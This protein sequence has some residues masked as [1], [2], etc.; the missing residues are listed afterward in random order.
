MHWDDLE[1]LGTVIGEGSLSGAARV[2]GLSQPTVGR[3]IRALEDAVGSTLIERVPEG[4]RPTALALAMLPHVDAMKRAAGELGRVVRGHAPDPSGSVRIACGFMVGRFLAIH[5]AELLEGA[6]DLRLVIDA[7]LAT[8]NLDRGDAD[9][10]LRANRP[11]SGNLYAKK[12][13]NNMYAVHGSRRYVEANP[14]ALGEDRYEG[15]RW[16]GYDEGHAH[17]AS[18]KWLA[19]RRSRAPE[20]QCTSSLLYF[21]AVVAG[22]GLGLLPTML[23]DRD[24]LVRLG[25]PLPELAYDMWLVAHRD[26][27]SIPRVRFVM[28]RVTA[29]VEARLADLSDDP[30]DD[31]A[32]DPEPDPAQ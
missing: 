16:V 24:D 2:L 9:L 6:P 22:A 29:L 26:A 12:I 15:C 20:L 5:T 10:A 27:R 23:G 3:R 17:L 31:P 32:P 7:D 1:L 4:I 8:V 18:A 14:Q 30:A 13:G 11:E 21:D 25:D 19:A 28:D